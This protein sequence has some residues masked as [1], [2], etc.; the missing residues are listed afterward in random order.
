MHKLHYFALLNIIV[1][2][3]FCLLHW[4]GGVLACCSYFDCSCCYLELLN[5]VFKASILICWLPK[6]SQFSCSLLAL[7][8]LSFPRQEQYTST[9]SKTW[10]LQMNKAGLR[11]NTR[12]CERN[13]LGVLFQSALL[14]TFSSSLVYL[15]IPLVSRDPFIYW[16]QRER[17]DSN[18]LLH[19]TAASK[20]QLINMTKRLYGK[21]YF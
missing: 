13:L 3:Y 21:I 5:C 14:G 11:P 10:Y 18:P 2:N 7:A 8:S 17:E 12:H 4:W 1:S 16:T 15:I 9:S 19:R 20:G 6:G